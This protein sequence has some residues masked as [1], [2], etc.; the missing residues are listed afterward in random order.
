MNSITIRFQSHIGA[1]RMRFNLSPELKKKL[2][3]SHI[4]AIRISGSVNCERKFAYFNPTLV[5]LEF[6]FLEQIK[7]KNPNSF[8][9][10]IGAIRIVENA[11]NQFIIPSFQSH[12][13]AIRIATTRRNLTQICYFFRTFP[14]QTSS[15]G[16]R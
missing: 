9:S 12:I 16:D 11:V 15:G 1:I 5:Q 6:N 10:H 2:F 13:G 4:G 14:N 7:I 3:Q 8:Q